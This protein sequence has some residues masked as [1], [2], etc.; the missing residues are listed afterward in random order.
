MCVLH[1]C[2]YRNCVENAKKDASEPVESIL[3]LQGR[4]VREGCLSYLASTTIDGRTDGR[5]KEG[6]LASAPTHTRRRR[7]QSII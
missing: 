3:H 5:T 4:D 1:V 7:S 2:I 6:W